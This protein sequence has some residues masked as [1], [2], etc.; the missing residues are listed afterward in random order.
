MKQKRWFVTF[1]GKP[2]KGVVNDLEIAG[3]Y[4]AYERL[5]SLGTFHVEA[6]ALLTS[7]NPPKRHPEIV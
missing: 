1:T 3:I 6:G 5:I 7:N 2:I 4:L